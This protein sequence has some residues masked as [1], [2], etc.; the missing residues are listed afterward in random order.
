MED[1]KKKYNL[2]EEDIKIRRRKKEDNDEE[3][4]EDYWRPEK[5]K[6]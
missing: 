6:G 5:T 1:W 3:T 4:L 2:N